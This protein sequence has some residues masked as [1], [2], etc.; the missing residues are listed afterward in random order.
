MGSV[1]IGVSVNFRMFWDPLSDNPGIP[2]DGLE[3]LVIHLGSIYGPSSLSDPEER[4]SGDE[5]IIKYEKVTLIL[6]PGRALSVYDEDPRRP[7]ETYW[8]ISYIV[9]GFVWVLLAK[10]YVLEVV[11]LEEISRR[12]AF[13]P[14]FDLVEVIRIQMRES[15]KKLR[16]AEEK[17]RKSV[18]DI[19]FVRMD[20]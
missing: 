3:E 8:Q 20:D 4:A 1:D 2:P 6:Q 12:L 7:S 5:T 9:D 10:P 14:S 15:L 13:G 18:G 16:W 11:G 17:V 19:V